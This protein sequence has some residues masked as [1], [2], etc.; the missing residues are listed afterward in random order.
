MND[1]GEPVGGGEAELY[2]EPQR[3]RVPSRKCQV[4]IY[5]YNIQFSG[6][7]GSSPDPTVMKKPVLETTLAIQ[8]YFHLITMYEKFDFRG[9]FNLR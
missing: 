5:F 8:P 4:I 6:S 3:T 2:H 7:G 1:K 9:I